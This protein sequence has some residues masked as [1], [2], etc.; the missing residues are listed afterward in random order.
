MRTNRDRKRIRKQTRQRKLRHLRERLAKA[1]NATEQKRL[2]EKIRRV[3]RTA[4]IP[5]V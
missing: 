3:S 2:I 5:G 4:P 1:N